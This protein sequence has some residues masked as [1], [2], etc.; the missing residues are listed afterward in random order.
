M[1]EPTTPADAQDL[2]QQVLSR[3]QELLEEAEAV[4]QEER[5]TAL[6]DLISADRAAQRTLYLHPEQASD[7]AVRYTR[8]RAG[9]DRS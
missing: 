1:P 7:L 6:E 2:I 4:G 3:H 5:V 8:L 9:L